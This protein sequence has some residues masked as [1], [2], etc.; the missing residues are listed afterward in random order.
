M[1][2]G[3]SWHQGR[4]HVQ[5]GNQTPRTLVSL[6]PIGVSHVGY[7]YCFGL[8]AAGMDKAAFAN[9]D[10][11]VRKGSIHGVEKNE[12]ARLEIGDFMH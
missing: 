10:A 6:G 7:H 5:W 2:S 1:A 4:V 12:V 3:L 9:I 8:A 11:Y